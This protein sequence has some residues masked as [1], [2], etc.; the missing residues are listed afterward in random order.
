MRPVLPLDV[1]AAARALLA[2]PDAERN[3]VCQRMLAQADA[4]DRYVRRTRKLHPHWGNGTLL[5]AARQW[6]L[7]GEKSFD[8]RGYRDC[9][10]MVL[11]H[12]DERAGQISCKPA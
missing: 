4:A 11:R 12:L 10:M 3:V 1:A 8:D 7:A 6:P 2:L 9:T 5:S